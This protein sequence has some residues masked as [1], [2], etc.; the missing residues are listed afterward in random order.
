MRNLKIALFL[1]ILLIN[2]CSV[3][4]EYPT[5]MRGGVDY[6]VHT[7]DPGNTLFAISKMYSIPVEAL[8][9]SNKNAAEGL[10]IGQEVLVPI[11]AV[12]KRTARRSSVS[13]DGSFILHTVQRKETLFSLSKDYG[14]DVNALIA[15]NPGA[16]QNLKT[17]DVIRIPGDTNKNANAVYLE[18]ASS[19]T[20]LVHSVM[21]GDTYYN[22]SKRYKITEDAL[23]AAN[24]GFPNGLKI[25]DYITIPKYKEKF[26]ESQRDSN[27]VA[28]TDS[29]AITR[30][31]KGMKEAYTIGLYLPFEIELN[32]SLDRALSQK[33]DLNIFTEVALDYYRGSLLALDSLKRLG[34]DA[35]VYVYD[36]GGDVVD[37]RQLTKQQSFKE[38]DLIIGPMHKSSLA[39]I[40]DASRSQSTYL[41]SPNSFANEVFESNPYLFRAIASRE[42]LLRYL[43]N[44]VAIQHEDDNVLMVNSEKGSDWPYRKMFKESYNRAAGTFVNSISDSLRSVTKRLTDG[45]E[46]EKWLKKDQLNV[47]VVPSNEVTFVTD[48][49]TRLSRLSDTYDIQVYGLEKWLG[50]DDIDA[51]YKN[52][53]KLRLVVPTYIDYKQEKVISFLEQYRGAYEMEPSQYAYGFLG[54]DLML[55]FGKALLSQGLGFANNVSATEMGGLGANYRFDRSTTGLEMENKAVYI[56]EYDDFEIKAVN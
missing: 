43:G 52:R 30:Y 4:Q 2:Q 26:L 6:Y 24:N 45:G 17:G 50:F 12:D 54:Y 3:A 10:Q 19:D 13:L 33:K 22:I 11:N 7:V 37:A 9:E 28:G 48:F 40:S 27:R 42:T 55:F 47:L 35:K 25:G 53:F 49:M 32:D 16:L 44:Y 39:V 29:S 34:F 31:P 18:P 36:L 5:V 51:A 46:V 21:K 8:L 15:N 38:M 1:L 14:V 56:I 20:F 41:V 23:A